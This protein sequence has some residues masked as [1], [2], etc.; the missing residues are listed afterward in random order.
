MQS[1]A[2]TSVTD[3]GVRIETIRPNISGL[4]INYAE[5]KEAMDE[6]GTAIGGVD[7]VGIIKVRK[8]RM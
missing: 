4:N 7:E 6:N 2:R 5:L 3:V 1:S 8:T